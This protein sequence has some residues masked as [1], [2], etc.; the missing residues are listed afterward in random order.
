MVGFL[1]KV[2]GVER[3]RDM[4]LRELFSPVLLLL[5]VLEKEDENDIGNLQLRGFLRFNGRKF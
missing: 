5:Q 1:T 4:T 3:R 2:V